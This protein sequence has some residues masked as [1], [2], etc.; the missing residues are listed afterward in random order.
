MLVDWLLALDRTH[1]S[2]FANCMQAGISVCVT[3][4][5]EHDCPPFLS[6]YRGVEGG[7]PRLL[8]LFAEEGVPATFFTTGD[9]CRRYPQVV[10]SIVSAGHE[11]G[12]HGDTHKRFGRMDESEA[13]REIESSSHVLRQHS[14]VVSFRAPNLDFP[15]P[16][17][18]LLRDNAYQ[19]DSSRGR[20]KLGSYFVKPS[21]QD[22]IRRIPA[23]IS[24]SPLRTPRVIRNV[25][26]GLLERPV[27]PFFHPWEFVDMTKEPLRFDNRLRTGEPAVQCLRETIRFFKDRGAQFRRIREIVVQ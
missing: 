22:G 23:S 6:S 21:I 14:D 26:C 11:L 12:C 15:D 2:I 13:R 5:M 8:R 16:F 10:D 24:P 27:V 19:V 3:I 4:D 20:H 7:T 9:V 1:Q 17:V 18:R 25:L